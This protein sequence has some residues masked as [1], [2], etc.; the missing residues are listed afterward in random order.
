MPGARL[1]GLGGVLKPEEHPLRLGIT[2]PAWAQRPELEAPQVHVLNNSNVGRAIVDGC[3]EL[4]RCRHVREVRAGT[5][6]QHERE[7]A[8]EPKQREYKHVERNASQG[9]PAHDE[10]LSAAAR[11]LISARRDPPAHTRTRKKKRL[12]GQC[13][14]NTALTP[15]T[16]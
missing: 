14:Q 15:A 7:Y 6:S 12:S 2:L 13:A 10:L 1:D 11:A 3:L 5:S 9:S 8:H 16:R 4:L